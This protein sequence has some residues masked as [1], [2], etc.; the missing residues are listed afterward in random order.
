L[1]LIVEI[2]GG[3]HETQKDY[4][5]FRDRII[6]RNDIKVIRFTNEVVINNFDVVIN[7]IAEARTPSPG[8][9]GEGQG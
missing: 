5:Q 2:D 6:S 3:I 9:P 1:K 4:D 7:R 8:L